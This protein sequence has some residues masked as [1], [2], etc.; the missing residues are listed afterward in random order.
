[1]S[2]AEHLEVH[3]YGSTVYRDMLKEFRNAEDEIN[4]EFYI[5]NDDRTGRLFAQELKKAAERGVDVRVVIDGFGSSDFPYPVFKDLRESGVDIRY[6]NPIKMYKGI[7][8]W[9]LRDHRKIVTID[10]KAGY[11]GGMNINRRHLH[12]DEL[13]D[14]PPEMS[15]K[16]TQVKVTGPRVRDI[17]NRFGET[18]QL[19]TGQEFEFSEPGEDTSSTI[20]GGKLRNRN[21]ALKDYVRRFREAEER[22][23]L[24][25]AYFVPPPYIREVL[26]E[27]VERGV[28]VRVVTP[29]TMDIVSVRS[30]S[31]YLFRELV[32]NGVKVYEYQD[33][34]IH[35]KTGVV[36]GEWAGI[37]SLNIDYQSV[38][39]NLELNI[40]TRRR[41]TAK[42]MERQF[43]EDL[44]S[45]ERVAKEDIE[46]RGSF[47]KFRNWFCHNF[48]WIY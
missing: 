33:N 10:E 4:L 46:N 39:R 22:I 43:V 6:Y 48:R 2:S 11:L 5:Y 16:D 47:S 28:D 42:E 37:G 34:L 24:T 35:S 8:R 14:M 19:M 25:Q 1:M 41:D 40:S 30:A 26:Y 9:V 12:P 15:I 44:D 7:W 27:A 13:E 36:D 18:W 21:N 23:W 3:R 29:G 20:L 45:S 17:R 31:K 38:L 32:E